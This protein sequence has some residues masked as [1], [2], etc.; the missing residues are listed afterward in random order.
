MTNGNGAEMEKR[1]KAAEQFADAMGYTGEK[2][3]Q[4]I[5]MELHPAFIGTLDFDV[6]VTMFDKTKR[7]L[8]RAEYQHTP[9]WEYF[10]LVLRRPY[11]GWQSSNYSLKLLTG[12]GK[13]K[14]WREYLGNDFDILDADLVFKA[15]DVE[16][17]RLDVER[18][19]ENLKG[20][21]K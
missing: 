17:Q 20:M 9:E 16:C 3:E 8:M 6:A 11:V 5:H 21:L 14:Q 15:I 7:Y 4:H 2:R 10:D 18:R 19:K 13:K 12:R 1:R